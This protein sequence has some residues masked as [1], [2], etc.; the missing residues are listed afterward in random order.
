M[1]DQRRAD[2]PY[3]AMDRGGN[4]FLAEAESLLGW[5]RD[6]GVDCAVQ[7]EPRDWLKPAPAPAN[8]EVAEAGAGAPRLRSGRAEVLEPLP[9][10]LPLFHDWLRASD[11]LPY[12]APHAPR[13]CPSGDPSSGLVVM[14]AMPS[15]EDCSAGTMLSGE[16][17]RLFDRMLAAIGRSRDTSYIAG[18]SCLRPAGGRIDPAGA[19]RCAEIAR[20]H[21]GLVAPKAVLLLGDACSKALLGIGAAQARGKVHRIAT[22]GGEIAAVVTLH[23]DYLLG[24]PAAKALAWADLQL[25]QETLA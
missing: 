18:L 23:P 4:D 3:G 7:E 13:V 17:G 9:D 2:S 8:N 1:V 6:A 10:Q 14:T 19:T 5:W 16:A 22:P 12:A 15:V 11:A 20:H 21:L 25:L 24:Q